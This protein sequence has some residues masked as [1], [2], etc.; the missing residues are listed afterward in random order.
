MNST[1][2]S[3]RR[4]LPASAVL[5]S[6]AAGALAGP[7]A[8]AAAATPQF[9]MISTTVVAPPN[10]MVGSDGRT[11]LVYEIALQNREL[12]RLELQSLSVRAHGRTLLTLRAAQLRAV[13]TNGAYSAAN[14]LAAGEGGTIW[15]DVPVPRGQ[16]PRGLTHRFTVRL[17]EPNGETAG[18]TVGPWKPSTVFVGAPTAVHTRRAPAIA[19]PLRGGPYLNFNGCCELS[20]HRTGLIAVDGTP[21]AAE[22]FAADFIRID[23][24]GRAFAGDVTGNESLYTY[25]EG[26][27][28]VADGRVT[29]VLNDQPDQPPLNEPAGSSFTTETVTGNNVTMRLADGRYASY[30]HLQRGSVRVHSGQRVRKGQLLARVGNSGQS[31]GAHLHFEL[32]AGPSPVASNGVPFELS[33]FS[34]LG[35]VTNVDAFVTGTASADVHRLSA[36]SPRR[37]QMPL[38]ATVVRFA[39]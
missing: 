12:K 34:L 33:A 6:L 3:L 20:P 10:P 31:G 38:H 19:P 13:M 7:S 30:M 17:T 2:S 16:I 29:D 25:G 4:A 9:T 21:Y 32:T 8:A 14:S 11:H 24:Q 5:A 39:S 22:R 18:S 35:H 27:Y 23:N 1:S 28:A 26:V 37:G 36:P 15:L